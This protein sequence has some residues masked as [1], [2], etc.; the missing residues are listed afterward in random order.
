MGPLSGL[1]TIS[2]S[3]YNWC[4]DGGLLSLVEEHK[5]TVPVVSVVPRPQG[6]L[7]LVHKFEV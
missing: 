2:K 5:D 3:C 1:A 6:V 7:A 4:E